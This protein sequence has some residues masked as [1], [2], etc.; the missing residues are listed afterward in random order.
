MLD[1]QL[2]QLRLVQSKM[3]KI[4]LVTLINIAFGFVNADDKIPSKI[5]LDAVMQNAVKQMNSQMT[6]L[7]IDEYTNLKFVAYD[8]NPPLFTYFYSSNVL[9][10]IKQDSLNHTQIEALNKFN[11]TKTCGTSFKPLMKPYN[12]K[13]AHIMDDKTTGKKIYK[14]TISHLDCQG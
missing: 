12:L 3:I 2:D 7:K 13:V 10:S 6:G 9:S 1:F 11:I 8:S 14:I 4:F 5:E